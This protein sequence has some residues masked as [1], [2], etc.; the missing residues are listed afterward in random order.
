MSSAGHFRLDGHSF[1]RRS[2]ASHRGFVNGNVGEVK[3]VSTTKRRAQRSQRM[4]FSTWVTLA[5]QTG[6][7]LA[8]VSVM[9]TIAGLYSVK[10]RG[11]RQWL[12]YVIS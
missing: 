3:H 7:M 1:S 9:S 11:T 5:A 12:R 2:A 6:D 4:P 8:V 10:A